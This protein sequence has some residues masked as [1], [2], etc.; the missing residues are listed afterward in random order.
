MKEHGHQF[1]DPSYLSPTQQISQACSSRSAFQNWLLLHFGHTW[2]T[3]MCITCPYWLLGIQP[4]KISNWTHFWKQSPAL[5]EAILANMSGKC[6]LFSSEF[7]QI[8]Q[9]RML[10]LSKAHL[11]G[12]RMTPTPTRGGETPRS[13]DASLW[14]LWPCWPNW[15]A[16][17]QN[18]YSTSILIDF[19]MQHGVWSW[20]VSTVNSTHL[21]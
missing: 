5:W 10:H 9:Q 4:Y 3:V 13:V 1:N 8:P 18:I 21:Y 14:L 6:S 15:I 20:L 16:D 11:G 2:G 7:L 17:L 19:K 12:N